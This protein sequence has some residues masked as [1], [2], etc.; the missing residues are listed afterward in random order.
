MTKT[1]SIALP[2]TLFLGVWGFAAL[3]LAV[4]IGLG[5][6]LILLLGGGL[7][8]LLARFRAQTRAV[9]AQLAR[10]EY[11]RVAKGQRFAADVE[12]WLRGH[13]KEA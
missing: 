4:R 6:A 9:D 11:E 2:L 1:P 12:A 7:A 13:H 3:P 8:W 5:A 10:Q